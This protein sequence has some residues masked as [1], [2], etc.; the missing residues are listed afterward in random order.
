MNKD[1]NIR[2]FKD[3]LAT[4]RKISKKEGRTLKAMFK[5]IIDYYQKLNKK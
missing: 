1:T 3:D 5:V 4:L 2:V